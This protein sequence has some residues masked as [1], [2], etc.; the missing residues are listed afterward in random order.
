M[1]EVPLFAALG[2]NADAIKFLQANVQRGFP[3]A[4][5]W[6]WYPSMDAVRR[7]PIFP[8]VAQ[9]LG[10]I[11]YWR[12]SHSKPDACSGKNPPRFCAII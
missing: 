8:A 11:K 10:L 2:D 7:D 6:L 3:G 5:E 1:P 4:R 12:A 9:R